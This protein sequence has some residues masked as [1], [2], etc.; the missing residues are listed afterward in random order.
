VENGQVEFYVNGEKVN[1]SGSGS[2]FGELALMYNSPRAATVV[3]ATDCNLWCLDRLTFR[4][5]LLGGSFKKRLMYD[6]FL[7]NLPLLSKLST[8]DRAK[9]ADAL[10]TEFYNKGDV[11]IKEGDIGE[12][13]YFIEYG[14]ALVLKESVEKPLTTLTKGSYFGE[15]ALL[16]DLPRQATVMANEDTKV[17]TLGK[18][19]FQRL[20]GPCVDV[21]KTQDPTRK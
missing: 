7:K 4:K 8:Y 6:E 3:A 13:F 20:L 18:S 15:I 19:G 21:L 11:I 17:V 10:N 12:N 1:T 16:N 9:L 2:S 14:S 5:I